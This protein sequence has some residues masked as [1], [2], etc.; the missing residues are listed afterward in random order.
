ME[1]ALFALLHQ[2][3]NMPPKRRTATVA[4]G[5]DD[6]NGLTD[7]MLKEILT[8]V[9]ENGDKLNANTTKLEN[10]EKKY[11]NLT[12]QL[13]TV[14][15]RVT[16]VE[17]E[18]V[19]ANDAVKHYQEAVRRMEIA[20]IRNEENS[21]R[22]NVIAYNV[23]EGHSTHESRK[24][25]FEK[26]YDLLGNV[27]G[28]DNP[29]II[30]I[31]EAHRLPTKSSEGR[32]PLIFKLTSMLHKDILWDHLPNVKKY[33]EGKPKSDKISINMTHLPSKLVKDK[34][35]LMDIYV[36]AKANGKSPK[37][38]YINVCLNSSTIAKYHDSYLSYS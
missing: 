19:A 11:E 29:N 24:I 35:D 5:E 14:D 26:M 33:N 25:S 3:G 8:A 38:R 6:I 28:I 21:R 22:F 10:L 15:S 9:R 1:C 36:E 18:S 31:S 27:F 30:N 7:V 32:K 12:L 2:Y 17:A 13:E 4:E 23:P 20:A 16:K 37:W 34:D